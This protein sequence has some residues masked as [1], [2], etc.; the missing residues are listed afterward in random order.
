MKTR[1]TTLGSRLLHLFLSMILAI[2]IGF[3]MS[4]PVSAL[5]GNCGSSTKWELN[6]G[7]LTLSGSGAVSIVGWAVYSDQVT[8]V[9]IGDGITSMNS[10][11]FVNSKNLKSVVFGKSV[12]TIPASFC[13][14]CPALSS[15]QFSDSVQKIDK[16]AFVNCGSL[17]KLE[18]PSSVTEIGSQA[19]SSCVGLQSLTIPD[20]VTTIADSAFKGTNIKTLKLGNKLKTIGKE[21]FQ[22]SCFSEVEIPD[23]VTTIGANA[24]GVVYTAVSRS[25]G[26]LNYYYTGT[27][28]KVTIIGKEGSV[29]QQF[30]NSG[31]FPF[32]TPG[33]A[34]HTHSWSDWSV[35]TAAGCESNGEEIRTCSGCKQSESQTIPATGHSFGEWK[36]E[37][38]ASCEKD[39]TNARTCSQCSKKETQTIPATGH[40]YGDWTVTKHPTVDAAGE[41][42]RV[43]AG[44]GNKQTAPIAALVGYTVVVSVSEGGTVTPSG[45]SKVAEGGRVTLKITPNQDYKLASVFVNGSEMRPNANN[46]ILLSDIRSNQNVS[47]VF[48]KKEQP[49]TRKCNFI[50]ITPKRA[51]WLTD[52]SGI[53][54]KDF[55]ISAN[56]T[57][58]GMV[59]WLDVT[60]D[61]VPDMNGMPAFSPYGSGT[62]KFRYQGGDTAVQEY[63]KQNGISVQIPLYHRGDGDGSGDVDVIDAEL[64]LHSYV[65]GLTGSANDGISEVQRT[66]LDADQNGETVLEDAVYILKYYTQKLSGIKPDWNK[67]LA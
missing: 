1:N 52:E 38:A 62:V 8:S 53:S 36:T 19:F 58:Q 29:A 7:V 66:V 20:S 30:A 5:D 40:S 41:Q 39:G 50:D 22:Y 67:I 33:S 48:Q 65:V 25:N 46:E 14:N 51:V 27:P 59:S 3:P 28:V 26:M 63:M 15:I 31:G 44:C 34:S 61:C 6:N 56:I 55:T 4:L 23:S 24:F 35:K 13:A 18:L 49:K 42:Q 54:A 9:V 12:Q 17:K 10:S 45:E 57:D 37:T 47:V 64:A 16:S 32:K 21:A 43:C 60:A 11:M 2:G